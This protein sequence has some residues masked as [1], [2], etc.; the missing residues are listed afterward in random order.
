MSSS[1]VTLA[2]SVSVQCTLSRKITSFRQ[3]E[4]AIVIGLE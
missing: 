2:F 3:S 4:N 1:A